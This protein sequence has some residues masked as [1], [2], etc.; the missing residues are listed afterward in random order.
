MISKEE[1]EKLLLDLENSRA[2]RTTSIAKTDK[3]GEAICAFC[4]DIPDSK[5]AGYLIIG[6]NDN[7]TLC[8]L[9]VTDELQLNIAAIRSDGNI[10]PQPAMAIEKFTFPDGELL[11]A[12]VQPSN[13]PPVRYKGKIWIRVGPRR[14]IANEAEE[15]ILY[16]KRAANI[17]TFDAMPCTDAGID[18]LDLALFKTEYLPKAFPENVLLEDNREK[19]QKLQSLGF[20]DLRFDCPTYAGIIMFGINPEKFLSGCYTQYV[21]FA[22][23]TRAGEI[24]SEHKFDGN[25]VRALSKMDTFI[26]LSI[27]KEKPVSVSPLREVKEISYPYFATREL[28]MN[29]VMHRD[30]ESNSPT[31]FYEFDSYIEIQNPGGLYGKARPENFPDVND[32]RNPVIAEAMK[33]LGYVNRY[34]RGIIRVQKELKEN[35][36]AEAIFDLTLVTAFKVVEPTSEKT[37]VGSK[38]IE[39]SAKQKAILE[40]CRVARSREE[41]FASLGITNQT[42]NYQ[43]HMLPLIDLGYLNYT[44]PEKKDIKGQR[45]ILTTLGSSYLDFYS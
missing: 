16:E 4:N 31:R 22:G 24:L 11:V 1:L 20:F 44:K 37:K 8:G 39:L 41:I 38:T 40:Y 18:D 3:F 7:G 45:Y 14:A 36:N 35:G 30:Y 29:A 34:N 2:E 32:Y 28:L 27:A 43:Q 26:E 6:A 42:I 10:Q 21:R 19:K 12:E 13:F 9:G 5:Q 17:K 33:V 25:L 15:K 23:E